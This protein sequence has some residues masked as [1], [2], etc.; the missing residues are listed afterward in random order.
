MARIAGEGYGN[1]L[2]E[3]YPFLEA[4][5][6]YCAKEE[7]AETVIDV[8]ARR[9]RLAFLDAEAAEKCIPRVI[10][11]MKKVHGW[12]EERC[13]KEKEE[14]EYFMHFMKVKYLF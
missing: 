10:E 3:D 11:L 9:T 1:K 6:L 13:K 12:S 7:Y 8:L 5:V 2:S 4:E 14:A